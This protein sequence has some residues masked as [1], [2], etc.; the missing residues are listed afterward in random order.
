[1]A[2]PVWGNLAKALDDDTTIDEAIAAAIATHEADADAHTGTG[3]S[4]ETHKGQAVVDHPLGSIVADKATFSELA[5]RTAFESLD[6]WSTVGDVT[7][8][9]FPGC[10]LYVEYGAVN[11]SKLYSNPQVPTN[12]F[13]SAKD[14]LYQIMCKFSLSNTHF[15]AWLGFITDHASTTAG[16]GF[17]I[18][19]GVLKAHVRAG[20]TTTESDAITCTLSNDHIFRAQYNATTGYVYFYIDGTLVATIAK[21]TGTWEDDTGPNLGIEVAQSNDGNLFT[22]DLYVSRQI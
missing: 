10:S 18:N 4:L 2:E 7:N 16:F 12:F 8:T 3:E 13:N 6:G 17:V 9:T 21:P 1:M 22:G 11:T 14:M 20:S 19:D 15:N 5:I